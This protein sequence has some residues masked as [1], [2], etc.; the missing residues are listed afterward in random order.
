MTA[1][2]PDR[3]GTAAQKWV[4]SGPGCKEKILMLKEF[5]ID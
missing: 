2:A 5:R 3:I 1:A 4:E